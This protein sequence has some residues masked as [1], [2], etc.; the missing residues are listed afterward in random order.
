MTATTTTTATV[1]TENSE[2]DPPSAAGEQLCE[3]A[4]CTDLSRIA[5][6]CEAADGPL[7]DR[8]GHTA[9]HWAALNSSPGALLALL[10]RTRHAV[11][12]GS[13]APAQLGQTA[14][15]WAVVAGNSACAAAL[16]QAGADASAR[17]ARGY[18]SLVHCAQ[19]GRVDLA[20]VLVLAGG[21]SIVDAPDNDGRG[22]LHWAAHAGWLSMVA[23][24]A[25]VAD[26]PATVDATD[27]AGQSALHKACARGHELVARALVSAGADASLRDNIGTPALE[28]PA[29]A[30][31]DGGVSGWGSRLR[32][33]GL[34]LFYYAVLG[35]SYWFY[36]AYVDFV[37]P[38]PGLY[39]WLFTTMLCISLGTH[40][41]ATYADPGELPLGSARA[42]RGDIETSIARGVA[43][44][45]LGPSRYCFT[46]MRA[47]VPR[48]KH[49]RSRGRCVRRFD[50]ECPWINNAVGLR[51]HRPL[52][53][54]AA[55]MLLLQ[56]MFLD[57]LRAALVEDPAVRSLWDAAAKR[58]LAIALG[59]LHGALAAFCA[60]LLVQHLYLAA[61]GLT[62]YEQ[63]A[64]KRMGMRKN[65][66][67]FGV[68]RNIVDFLMAT[69]PGTGTGTGE[70]C[71]VADEG[72]SE[73]VVRNGI[74]HAVEG[75]GDQEEQL[76]G[77][78][79]VTQRLLAQ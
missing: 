36:L 12:A 22:P 54:F 24:L 16:L 38:R 62:T 53:V 47:R 44:V 39:A 40:S 57:Q 1:T 74:D 78:G 77:E 4:R 23:Y 19:Y 2:A 59:T 33:H 30:W 55:S 79:D 35:V 34:V 37:A 8:A 42:C 15:H 68:K 18:S 17:D 28:G 49:S 13:L 41:F 3:A 66:Y 50:H 20:H 71:P 9:L 7:R 32:A 43:E 63:I 51:N 29:E 14:L 76:D 26:P 31:G 10:P 56:A 73:I 70:A 75:G 25:V 69:G 72:L 45:A 11:D 58:P 5:S 64:Y 48:S 6:L 46:C 67:D 60:I 21:P 65:P 52:L 27:H 61:K